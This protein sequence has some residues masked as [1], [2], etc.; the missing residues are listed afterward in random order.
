MYHYS[1]FKEGQS[2]V[3][4]EYD[5]KTDNAPKIIASG[6]GVIAKQILE[7]ARSNNIPIHQNAD[8]VQILSLLEI[9][10]FIPVEVY[11]VVAKILMHI[12]KLNTKAKIKK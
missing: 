7:I 5:Q 11:D 8:L 2:A 4:L 12:N 9:N 6:R 1:N 3:A 10:S